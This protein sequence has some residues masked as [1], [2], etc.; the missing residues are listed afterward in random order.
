[1]KQVKLR[2]FPFPCLLLCAITLLAFSVSALAAEVTLAWDP[3]TEPDLAGYRIYYG[4]APGVYGTTITIGM[5]TTYAVTNLSPGTWYFAITAFN[6]SGLE[7]GYSNEVSTT[8]TAPPM[9]SS[10]TGAS[11]TETSA[12]ISWTTNQDS[13]SQVQYGLTT[14][15]GSSTNLNA[16]MVS[17]HSQVLSGLASGTLYHYR[18]LSR[19]AAG[20]VSV[21]A[22]YTFTTAGDPWEPAT[23]HYYPRLFSSPADGQSVPN[24]EFI[25]LGI[26]NLDDE[27]ALFRFTAFNKDG[28]RISG[29]DIANPVER[30]LRPNEQLAIIDNQLFG[31]GLNAAD[32]MGWVKI[33]SG[34]SE[35]VG[36]FLM[37]D[38]SVNELGGANAG[39]AVLTTFLFP[40]ISSQGFNRVNIANPDAEPAALIF[41]LLK[42]DGT[43]LT[44]TTRE[45]PPYGALVAD[46][47][48]DIFTGVAADATGYARVKASKGVLPFELVGKTSQYIMGMNG[49]DTAQ[50]A[51]TLYCPQFAAGG[52]WRTALSIINLE[53]RPGTVML[54]FIGDGS[55]QI[56]TTQTLPIE[57]NGKIYIDEQASFQASISGPGSDA[58]TGY[59]VIAGSGIRLTG[60][61]VFSDPDQAAFS[62]ALPLA[63]SLERQAVYSHI[64]SDDRYFT[65]LAILNPGDFDA[66]V[67]ISVFNS[68]ATLAMAKTFGL[69]RGERISGVLTDTF[70]ELASQPRTSGYFTVVSDQPLAS[71]A[72]FGTRNLTALSAIPP[73]IV[74]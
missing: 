33:E 72:L 55:S 26:A 48:S 51:H 2:L 23:T 6:T 46:L 35:V 73:Q 58:Q 15:Y 16:S 67:T 69:G 20:N 31:A 61:V 47:F 34:V 13:D 56:G 25:G 45:V 1:M 10:M 71:F 17:S 11:I 53:S 12:T 57:A 65:G 29:P 64:A 28:V 54:R 59:V 70:P 74:R 8:I 40:E 3:N 42:G 60:S 5:Q 24:Q 44:S 7:S 9:L 27:S 38:G 49:Q 21:S 52:Q 19:D 36:F 63:A 39:T 50:G 18:V 37:F 30:T 41:Q 32:T 62:A 68:D 66:T 4:S 22:D 14:G 43:E